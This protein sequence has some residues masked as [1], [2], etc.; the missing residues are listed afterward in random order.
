[1]IEIL[2]LS[3]LTS[4]VVSTAYWFLK[5]AESDNLLVKKIFQN[6]SNFF[7]FIT[8]YYLKLSFFQI[9]ISSDKFIIFSQTF[10]SEKIRFFDSKLNILLNKKN[11]IFLR[12]KIWIWNVFIFIQWIKNII[13]YKKIK[14]CA[15]IFLLV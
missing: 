6:C 7:D 11:I 1:M 13:I 15:L 5:F 14:L 12:K 10:K 8:T 4:E 2:L 9:R 3:D